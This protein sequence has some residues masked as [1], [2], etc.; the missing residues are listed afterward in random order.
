MVF[1]YNGFSALFHHVEVA[2]GSVEATDEAGASDDAA[3]CFLTILE[4]VFARTNIAL[5]GHMNGDKLSSNNKQACR[6]TPVNVTN[7]EKAF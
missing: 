7:A 3:L 6:G 5:S 4:L 2:A 1:I